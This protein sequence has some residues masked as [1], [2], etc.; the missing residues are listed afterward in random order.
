VVP[1]H[2]SQV[3]ELAHNIAPLGDVAAD[4]KERSLDAVSGKN[5]QE[6]ERVRVVGTIIVGERQLARTTPKTNQASPIP[7]PLR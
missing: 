5:L 2:V 3:D 7:L 4:E 6:A 1:N